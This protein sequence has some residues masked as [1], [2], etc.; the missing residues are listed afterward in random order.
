MRRDDFENW[1]LSGDHGPRGRSISD[2][3]NRISRMEEQ[4]AINIDRFTTE[5][6][7]N[8]IP[9]WTNPQNFP[10]RSIRYTG[11]LRSAIRKY[12]EFMENNNQ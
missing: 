10:E 11:N 3:V 9:D 7:R 1:L 8:N 2:Y 5:Q 4:L 12:I 6:I